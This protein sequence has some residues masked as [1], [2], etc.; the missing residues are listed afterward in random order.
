MRVIVAGR[1]SKVA[2]D[3]DQTGFDSQEREAVRW[4]DA[5]RHEVVAVVA[6]FKSGRSG[7][8][9]RTNLRPWVTEPDRLALYDGILALKVDRLT[10]GNR[11]ETT[12]LENWAR[13]HGK[14][15]L[16]ASTG[17]R[18]PAEGRDGIAWD[19]YLRLAHEE[20][21]S[22]SERY[23]RM[24]RNRREHG[25]AIGRPAWGYEI[26]KTEGRKLFVPTDD[27]RM[28]VPQIFARII[29][30]Q[31]I[32]QLAAWLTAEGVSPERGNA[33]WSESWING[34]VRNPIYRGERRN[35]GSI[36]V[37]ALVSAQ[38]WETAGAILAGRATGGRGTTVHE[39]ALLQPV[40]WACYGQS[41]EGC[42][43][44]VSPM[45][46]LYMGKGRHRR[47][48]Y[49]CT[50]A[51]AGR[52]GCGT[53]LIPVDELDA[54]VIEWFSR[55]TQPH[56]RRTFNAGRNVAEGIAALNK[57]IS[58]AVAV[59]DYATVA[60]LS[61][62]AEALKNAEDARPSWTITPSDQTMGQHFAGLDAEG[63][64]AYISEGR[65]ILAQKIDGH[66]VVG[67]HL[68]DGPIFRWIEDGETVKL[69][70]TQEA[71]KRYMTQDAG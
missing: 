5:E 46:R 37:E 52:K 45:Y 12:K 32:R 6:D 17:V 51:G 39:K 22:I 8:D 11:E 3:R 15:L 27:G 33:V 60:T 50:G 56:M 69:E 48:Y 49:R 28:Y 19:M 41:R 38:V 66:L 13:E 42:A 61:A 35:G 16:I 64:R 36:E 54:R 29:D 67:E 68:E 24:Q 26:A 63:Q 30:G 70:K 47:P 23:T 34:M 31:S 14:V 58:D 10:R 18:F 21:L 7:L 2:S 1:L 65:L 59:L 62:E 43:S 53:A 71:L 55:S 40:C 57:R 4:A 9:A 20:W 44:G 25:S